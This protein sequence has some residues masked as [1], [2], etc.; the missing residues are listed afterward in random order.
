MKNVGIITING[1]INYGN[2]LQNFALHYILNKYGFK[3]FSIWEKKSPLHNFLS[4]IKRLIFSFLPVKFF[5]KSLIYKREKIFKKFDKKFIKRYYV[6]RENV[7][8]LGDF[9]SY[10]IIGSDQVWNPNAV[11]YYFGFEIFRSNVKLIAY[12]PSIA[13]NSVPEDFEINIRNL[14]TFDNIKYLSLREK[15]GC[16]LVAK[17]TGRNDVYNLIDPTLLVDF[18]VWDKLIKKPKCFNN[19]KYILLY[20]LGDISDARR[21]VINEYA[22]KY[23]LDIID[24]LDKDS[25]YFLTG[26]SEFLFLEKNAEL[27]CTDSFHSSVFAFLFKKRFFIF[28]REDTK[29]NMSSRL[30]DFISKFMLED[31]KFKIEIGLDVKFDYSKS[32]NILEDERQKSKDFLERALDIKK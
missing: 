23:N 15:T 4:K 10:C 2:K 12:A 16:E 29:E 8:S 3:S 26:P 18:S 22:C 11:N 21:S 13:V 7:K 31:N 24:I 25:D 1:D 30:D 32:F 28:D 6:R 19:K 5:N 17:I 9:F 27:I 20:F 14:L